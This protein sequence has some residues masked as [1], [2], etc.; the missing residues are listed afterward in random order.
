MQTIPLCGITTEL[1]GRE[2]L[3]KPSSC[4]MKSKLIPL[5]L[6]EL[7]GTLNSPETRVMSNQTRIINF[8]PCYKA[9]SGALILIRRSSNSTVNLV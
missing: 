8:Q 4:R 2:T 3:T 7:L 1:T 5:R 9:T 6:N